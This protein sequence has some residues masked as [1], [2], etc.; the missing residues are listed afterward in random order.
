MINIDLEAECSPGLHSS[1][2]IGSPENHICSA[3]L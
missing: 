1:L 2:F 3:V